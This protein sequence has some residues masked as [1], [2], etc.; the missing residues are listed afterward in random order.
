MGVPAQTLSYSLG[1][2]SVNKEKKKKS[3]QISPMKEKPR[4]RDEPKLF[5]KDIRQW[6]DSTVVGHKTEKETICKGKF[7]NRK[8]RVSHKD[9]LCGICMSSLVL[10]G[11]D[12]SLNCFHAVCWC[13]SLRLRYLLKSK[14]CPFCKNTIETLFF[15]SNPG[16]FEYL[17]DDSLEGL[18]DRSMELEKREKINDVRVALGHLKLEEI[19]KSL[20]DEKV[21]VVFESYACRWAI[22]RIL[23][24]RCWFPGCRP[25]FPTGDQECTSNASMFKSVKALG[26]HLFQ[27]HHVK[28]CYVCI[29]KR[30]TMLL[31]EHY[32]YG[33]K[34]LSRHLNKGE[35]SLKPPILP[36]ISCPICKVWCFDREDFSDHVRNEHF[37]CHICEE[38][39]LSRQSEESQP[40]GSTETEEAAACVQ[41]QRG[42]YGEEEE[43]ADGARGQVGAP[44]DRSHRTPRITYVYKDYRMLQEHWRQKHFPCDHENCMFIVFENES[45]LIFH[46]ATHHSAANRRGNT[47]VPIMVSSYRQQNQRRTDHVASSHRGAAQTASNPRVPNPQE[48]STPSLCAMDELS[49]TILTRLRQEKPLLWRLVL[50]HD[51]SRCLQV[52]EDEL[53]VKLGLEEKCR[54]FSSWSLQVINDLFSSN[55]AMIGTIQRLGSAY[56]KRVVSAQAFVAEMVSLL[57]GSSYNHSS[58]T[59]LLQNIKKQFKGITASP[60]SFKIFFS[61]VS[62]PVTIFEDSLKDRSGV[63]K[64][65]PAQL[66][67]RI[68]IDEAN[69]SLLYSEVISMVLISLILGLPKIESRKELCKSLQVLRDDIRQKSVTVVSNTSFPRFSFG[70]LN[71]PPE[72]EGLHVDS[73][74]QTESLP[75]EEP[76]SRKREIKQKFISFEKLIKPE[77]ILISPKVT[78]LES[79]H[80]FLS[81]CLPKASLSQLQ[82][83][84]PDKS[85]KEKISDKFEILIGSQTP[86]EINTLSSLYQHTSNLVS[87]ANTIERILGL[88][89]PFY[90]LAIN[91]SGSPED[92]QAQKASTE[93]LIHKQWLNLCTKAF[94]KICLYDI[95]IVLLY[96]KACSKT[97]KDPNFLEKQ[98]E[99]L[100]E[101][102]KQKDLSE[103]FPKTVNAS[104]G[105]I[106]HSAKPLTTSSLSLRTNSSGSWASKTYLSANNSVPKTVLATSLPIQPCVSLSS[107]SSSSSGA[108]SY[109]QTLKNREAVSKPKAEKGA[110]PKETN[111][112]P[113][114]ISKGENKG[115]AR[116]K[117]E[118]PPKWVCILCTHV[119]SGSRNRCQI[120]STRK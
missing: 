11:L 64:R 86:T 9:K 59:T 74:G 79:L 38:K 23:E 3:K 31:P 56:C 60:S 40:R 57:W 77:E 55:Q 117:P 33:V 8:S 83:F 66:V 112:F 4:G 87:S 78:F 42:E 97:L 32:L 92:P 22:E 103:S 43:P 13:C 85:E 48:I 29:E 70:S 106:S 54:D 100:H 114:L 109:A 45:E 50:V 105:V 107:S 7:G 27:R 93:S 26:E 120:C 94:N 81:V 88:R 65:I 62:E 46:K 12:F 104:S 89:A 2:I 21:G 96:C 16:Y 36:H 95:E 108:T 15:T 44:A 10:F 115:K 37:S 68:L 30:E 63:Y 1:L 52:V 53:V 76:V 102:N 41:A 24:Y 18:A 67:D 47:T 75:Q 73:R 20:I 98:K 71:S 82:E 51:L 116:M 5:A 111:E 118:N 90:R 113:E 25:K 80:S 119:N 6:V 110:K 101:Q 34:D 69:W 19:P 91:T 17:I 39:E 28:C 14:E 72:I 58:N 84:L 35:M 61:P 49:N 99:E